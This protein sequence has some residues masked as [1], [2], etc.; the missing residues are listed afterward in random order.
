PGYVPAAV[1]DASLT[2]VAGQGTGTVAVQVLNPALVPDGHTFRLTF[3]GLT[4]S[5]RALSYSLVDE[6]TGEEI[7]DSG[8]DLDG[9][10]VGPTGAGLLPIVTTPRTVEVDSAGTGFTAGDAVVPIRVGYLA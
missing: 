9:L 6:T 10:G 5:V 3:H 2:H 4:D 8:T 1:D 7:F